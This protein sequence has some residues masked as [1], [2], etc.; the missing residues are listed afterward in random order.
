MKY[1]EI[2]GVVVEIVGVD[3][4]SKVPLV[5]S[6]LISLSSALD[7]ASNQSSASLL[8]VSDSKHS[9]GRQSENSSAQWVAPPLA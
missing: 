3:D 5:S 9:G 6:G 4:N 7:R 8:M 2:S 1:K